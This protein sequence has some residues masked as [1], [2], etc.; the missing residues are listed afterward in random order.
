M[1]IPSPIVFLSFPP[2]SSLSSLPSSLS[3]PFLS[4]TISV[5]TLSSLTQSQGELIEA[6]QLG[7][8]GADCVPGLLL[9]SQVT[10]VL[11]CLQEDNK[12]HTDTL[13]LHPKYQLTE[14]FFPPVLLSNIIFG[15]HLLAHNPL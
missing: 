1:T 10:W 8:Q 3:S 13:M 14:L 9:Q 15:I 11:Y 7:H 4:Y 6:F 12:I 2:L 5:T